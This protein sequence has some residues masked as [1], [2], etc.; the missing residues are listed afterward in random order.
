MTN[1][2]VQSKLA[3]CEGV[4]RLLTVKLEELIAENDR[5]RGEVARL[6]EG[7]NALSTLQS[8]Y[9]NGELSKSLRAKAAGLALPHEVP[10]IHSVPP[11]L[12]LQ[13]E[14]VECLADVVARQRAR[15]DRLQGRQDIQ[16]LP[17]G[18]VHLLEP[19]G[20]GGNGS[21]DSQG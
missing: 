3:E 16:V 2:D 20:N 13:A 19:N 17:S 6:T 12:E 4:I 18:Q 14:P 10:K 8:L 7:A 11:A 1:T 5:L 9:R 15:Q 21:D